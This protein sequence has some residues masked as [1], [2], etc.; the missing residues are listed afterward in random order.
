[1]LYRPPNSTASEVNE[2]DNSP[3]DRD[4]RGHSSGTRSELVHIGGS[5]LS[6]RNM[7]LS[8]NRFRCQID[9]IEQRIVL[10][11]LFVKSLRSKLA[12]VE[13]WSSLGEQAHSLCQMKRWISR[14]KEGDLSSEDD[15]RPGRRLSELAG[16]IRR[17]FDK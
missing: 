14:F 8:E 5:H 12:R 4:T 13:L 17:H 7:S 11:F 16:G 15:H 1:V 9:Q 2:S 6:R 3:M 10:K